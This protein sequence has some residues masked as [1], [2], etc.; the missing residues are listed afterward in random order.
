MEAVQLKLKQASVVLGVPPKELQNFVQFGVLR[1]RRRAD[2]FW[3]DT[4]LLLQAK[5]AF[6]VK[7]SL[8]PSMEY[9]AQMTKEV[10]QV[11]LM[12]TNWDALLFASSPGK[13]KPP[14]EIKVPLNELKKELEEGLPLAD[15]CRDLPRGRK[16]R[17]WKEDLINTLQQAGQDI[18][19][20]S[21]REIAKKVRAYRSERKKQPEIR[22]VTQDQKS[23]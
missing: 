16:R 9:L 13:G 6:Y 5:V 15:A 8:R 19:S 22:L 4:N 12:T 20:L 3:F 10:S 11:N 2:V 18:G 17:G 14:V 23:A 7:A 21:E 1:P